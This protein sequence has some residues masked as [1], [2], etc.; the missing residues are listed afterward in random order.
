MTTTADELEE[1]IRSL[2]TGKSPK[3]Y[4]VTAEHNICGPYRYSVIEIL[5]HTYNAIF[6]VQS[7]P[8]AQKLGA[9]TPV[10]KHKGSKM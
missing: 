1:A 7:V 4:G 10:F 3:M 6:K 5:C 8:D 2:N 9:L